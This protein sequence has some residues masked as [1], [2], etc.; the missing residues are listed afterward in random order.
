MNASVVDSELAY[1][2]QPG[3]FTTLGEHAALVDALPADVASLAAT[4]QGLLIHRFW[5]R[6][7]GTTIDEAREREQ[8][9]HG[10]E[11]MLSRALA[12]DVSPL[13]QARTP[14]HRVTVICRHF[15]V[16]LSAFLRHKGIAARA[17]CG[18]ASYFERGKYVDHWVCEYYDAERGRWTLVDA[19]IDALQRAAIRP[20]FDPLDVPRERFWVAGQAWQRGR[21]GEADPLLFGIADMWG[22]GYISGNV[23]HD[24]AALNNVELLP[25][26]P[27]GLGVHPPDERDAATIDDI[28]ALSVSGR[29]DDVA[30][31]RALC[32]R[33]DDLRVPDTLIA[34]ALA[35]DASGPAAGNPLDA[36]LR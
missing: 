24:V 6:A 11:A 7:Y 30:A 29:D 27:F 8:G 28:A 9:L 14:G 32:A 3:P 16:L 20:D 2:R 33:R 5:A 18:F 22:L 36:A 4:V 23:L 31:L 1:Y 15:A 21:A 17:R 35:S 13:A 26:E 19:Q 25:W 34:T 10:A 12:L